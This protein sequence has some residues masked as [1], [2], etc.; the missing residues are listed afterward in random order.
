MKIASF[1]K[2]FLPMVFLVAIGTKL[3]AV[4]NE[5]E[6]KLSHG[7]ETYAAATAALLAGDSQTAYVLFIKSSY[8]L[9][10]P[11]HKA[12]ALYEAANVGWVGEIADYNTLVSLYKQSLRY[13]PG[14]YEA[15]FNLEYLYW[16]RV[17]APEDLPEPEPGPEPSREERTPNGDV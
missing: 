6:T 3:I 9:A 17:N 5:Q 12:V 10:D 16:L 7:Y 15:A 4:S 11:A 2:W 1:L 13:D 14:F 8:E